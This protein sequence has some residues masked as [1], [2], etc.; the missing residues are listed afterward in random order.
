LLVTAVGNGLFEEV[1]WRG[2]FVKFFRRSIL[3]AI[4]WPSLWFALWHYAPG[5]VSDSGGVARLM[6]GAA[7]FGLYLSYLARRTGT[8]FWGVLAHTLTGVIMVL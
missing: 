1:F 3:L 7:F 8:I 2:M 6:V 4:V 5:S